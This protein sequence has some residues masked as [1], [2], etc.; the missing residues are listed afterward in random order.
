MNDFFSLLRI[1]S[2]ELH[3]GFEKASI[4]GK[5]TPQ[6]IA[7]RREECFKTFISKYFPFP[8]R[9]VK[10]N[11]IDSYGHRSDSIDCIVLS[12][13]HPFTID[14]VSNKASMIFADG[15]DYAIEIK[16]KL[17]SREEIHRSLK[18]IGS[19]KM[20]QRARDTLMFP[21]EYSEEYREWIK[22][23]PAI[24]FADETYSSVEKLISEM[25]EYY[26]AEKITTIE[27]FDL[28]VINRKAI[29][30]N[31]SKFSCYEK[32]PRGIYWKEL[33]EDTLA[34]FLLRLNV[35]PPAEPPIAENIIS[36]YLKG[37]NSLPFATSVEINRKLI[38]ASI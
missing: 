15:V 20:L 11:I 5:S 12:P 35:I 27:Q 23:V 33:G 18:Q 26:V 30:V 24:I 3:T 4:E 29:I 7:D 32:L 9:I 14:A 19:V 17:N 21:D 8:H 38:S 1:E 2:E 31:V 37:V 10:G 22:H 16:G 13:S 34:E 25:A 6:E 28:V 36:L